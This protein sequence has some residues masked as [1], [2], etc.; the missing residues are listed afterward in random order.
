MS[1]TDYS[2]DTDSDVSTVSD[3]SEKG[4]AWDDE[5]DDEIYVQEGADLVIPE[6]TSETQ[7]VFSPQFFS[8]CSD[9]DL[10]CRKGM[11]A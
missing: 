7:R 8:W 4:S 3:V 6:F 10:F 5:S 11:G 2:S 1:D 9:T